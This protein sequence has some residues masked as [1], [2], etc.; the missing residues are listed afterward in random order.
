MRRKIAAFLSLLAVLGTFS[1]NVYRRYFYQPDLTIVGF[2]DLSDGVGRQSLELL[3]AFKQ[4]FSISFLPTRPSK[5]N[6]VSSSLK[7]LLR[8]KYRPLGKV[9]IFEDLLWWPG[10]YKYRKMIDSGAEQS[11]KIAYS[12]VE[13]SKIPGEWVLILNE[14]F[15]AVAVPDKFLI[16]VYQKSGV[17]I[18]IFELPLGLDLSPLLEISLK[19]QPHHPFVFGNLSGCNDRKNQL[20]L[21]RAFAKTFGDNPNVKLRINCRAGEKEVSNAI[22]AE[23]EKLGQSNILFTQFRLEKSE[24]LRLFQEIDCYV[25]I[26]KG[27]GF[28]IQPREAMVLGIPVIATNNTAQQTL[29]ESG[30]V[31]TVSCS[32]KELA[33]YP[34]GDYYGHFSSC[35]LEEVANALKNVYENYD[36]YLQKGTEARAW[37][38]QYQYKNLK[39]L[40]ESLIKPKKIILGSENKITSTCL[41]TTSEKLY[42]KYQQLL[43]E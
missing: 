29:C 33:I 27:E 11:I 14:H 39:P 2:I 28:S 36:A 42:H 22:T 15:D 30:L 37:A 5:L 21:I 31:K 26:S 17:K 24:Y 34:W 23:L 35:T 18:P 43:K 40:Y 8:Q 13:S 1:Y 16:D 32:Q 6:D 12:M 38:A 10:E 9:V 19:A 7:R 4:D 20:L 41:M 3:D 25:N